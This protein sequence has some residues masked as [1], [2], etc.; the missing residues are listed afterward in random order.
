LDGDVLVA[1]A[2]AQTAL[3]GGAYIFERSAGTW[4]ERLHLVAPDGGPND[5]FGYSVALHGRSV[6][7]GA[8]QDNALAF[9][10]GAAYRYAASGDLSTF[11][12]NGA[13]QVTAGQIVTYTMQVANPGPSDASPTQLDDQMP[14]QCNEFSWTCTPSGGASCSSSGFGSI[15][16]QTSLPA[17]GSLVLV[18][19]CL[20]SPTATGTL[21][22]PL[23]LTPPYGWIDPNL[24]N[25]AATDS[26]PI[27][28]SP[29]ELMTFTLE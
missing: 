29:V 19:Q 6:F 3:Q 18:A 20:L 24:G 28:P 16:E 14:A 2:F 26:D 1:G 11:K 27:A 7:V 23:S 10:A 12:S 15:S 5:Y 17:G 22:N 25:N 21:T 13:S 4:T 8:S 9:N